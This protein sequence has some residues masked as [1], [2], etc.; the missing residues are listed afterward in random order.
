MAQTLGGIT[1]RIQ[2]TTLE[3]YVMDDGT[4][5]FIIGGKMQTFPDVLTV[6]KAWADLH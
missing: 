1:L 6:W 2:G 4:F 3:G 5:Q